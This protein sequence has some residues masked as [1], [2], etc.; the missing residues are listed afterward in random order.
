MSRKIMR[1]QLSSNQWNWGAFLL[2]PF[3]CV[4][5]QVWIGMI[6]ILPTILIS[7]M[8][9]ISLGSFSLLVLILK[10][11]L[12]S[13]LSGVFPAI[14]FCLV[15]ISGGVFLLAGK[16]MTMTIL[17]FFYIIISILMGLKGDKL[18]TNKMNRKQDIHKFDLEKRIWLSLGL[19]FFIP[20]DIMIFYLTEKSV[21]ISIDLVQL[22]GI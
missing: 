19:L 8:S 4:R 7:L 16:N 5:Y 6:S 17:T 10:T 11:K 21:S 20:L 1:N 18:A 13:L 15:Y 3:W 14:L 22:P 9:L 2:C 12:H